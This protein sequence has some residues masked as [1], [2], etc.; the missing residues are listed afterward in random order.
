MSFTITTDI[1]CDRCNDWTDGVSTYKIDLTAARALARNRGWTCPQ[2]RSTYQKDLC[3]M[4]NGR[5]SSK[6]SDG[7]YVWYEGM[8]PDQDTPKEKLEKI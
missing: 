4:C 5:A 8:K 7:N 3:P 1:F 6:M 2:K